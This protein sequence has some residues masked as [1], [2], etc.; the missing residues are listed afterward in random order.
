M[1]II[2]FMFKWYFFNDIWSWVNEFRCL[3]W[4]NHLTLDELML[5]SFSWV[6]PWI[7]VWDLG[8]GQYLFWTPDTLFWLESP[9]PSL[10]YDSQLDINIVCVLSAFFQVPQS[11][12]ALLDNGMKTCLYLSGVLGSP[13]EIF[14]ECVCAGHEAKSSFMEKSMIDVNCTGV[15]AAFRF[16]RCLLGLL[17]GLMW[18]QKASCW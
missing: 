6:A 4:T 16:D 13:L 9:H 12:H 17:R 7:P 10:C 5:D 2:S 1:K 18:A 14:R 11:R 3:E 8:Q 15:G